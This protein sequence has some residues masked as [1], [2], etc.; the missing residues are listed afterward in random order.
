M[1]WTSALFA[2]LVPVATAAFRDL[3]VAKPGV[4][5]ELPPQA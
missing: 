2:C 4:L 1:S 5:D 3:I